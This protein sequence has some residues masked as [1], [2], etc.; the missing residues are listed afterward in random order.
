MTGNSTMGHVR[1]EYTGDME[2]DEYYAAYEYPDTTNNSG[3]KLN[4]RRVE[5]MYVFVHIP[6]IS[7]E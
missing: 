5:N 2:V 7:N 4:L 6:K 3:N 1:S